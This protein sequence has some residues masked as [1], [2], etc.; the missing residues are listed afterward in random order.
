MTILKKVITT[1]SNCYLE[2]CQLSCQGNYLFQDD[3][4]ICIS[5]NIL[6]KGGTIPCPVDASGNFTD[7]V[8]D[9]KGLHVKVSRFCK[10]SQFSAFNLF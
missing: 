10:V 3:H 8:P 5:K 4:R 7:E 9:F 6:V 2:L 1:K